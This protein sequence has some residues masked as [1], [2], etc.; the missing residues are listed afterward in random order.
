MKTGIVMDISGGFATVM[1]QGGGFLTI[2]CQKGWMQGDLVTLPEKRR[3]PRLRAM[4]LAAA[5]LI[6]MVSLSALGY[7]SYTAPVA[8]I[9]L[10]VNPS[11]EL[12]V[13]RYGRIISSSSYNAEG[14]EILAESS[15]KNESFSKGLQV[16]LTG[17]L[18]LYLQQSPFITYS[19]QSD[20][21]VQKEKLLSELKNATNALNLMPALDTQIEA[22][23]Y[24]VDAPQV[25]AAH[26]HHVTAGKYATLLEL[27]QLMP[28]IEIEEYSHCS[29]GEIRQ[30][31][32]GCR[33]QSQNGG[34][35]AK[36]SG[37]HHAGHGHD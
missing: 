20:S 3:T 4:C 37:G 22:D 7:R 34:G 36:H 2:E 25:A 27:Q 26:S 28:D 19:V 23:Y 16:L 24:V 6:L 33:R 18:K 8:L 21:N 29:I 30:E 1:T 5:C 11:I 32:S 10:D 13:N 31:I 17:R 12:E 9:S 14:K 35:F 15:L